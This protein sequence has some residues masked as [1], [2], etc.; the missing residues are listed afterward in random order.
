VPRVRWGE[1]DAGFSAAGSVAP[2]SSCEV[3]P[4]LASAPA[5]GQRDGFQ[6]P[7]C[8]PQA[9]PPQSISASWP[10]AHP[11]IHDPA[12]RGM[13]TR[14]RSAHGVRAF[15]REFRTASWAGSCRAVCT[16]GVRGQRASSPSQKAIAAQRMHL[17]ADLP[18]LTE[19]ERHAHFISPEAGADA[20]L[21]VVGGDVIELG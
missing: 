12:P 15:R 8:A 1:E 4:V 9:H 19:T 10:V 3:A 13:P 20:H 14:H 7:V 21:H 2:A 11:A 16:R 5:L 17:D 18:F 6:A